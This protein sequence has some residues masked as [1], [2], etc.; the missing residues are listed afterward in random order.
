MAIVSSPVARHLQHIADS[1]VGD[2][3]DAAGCFIVCFSA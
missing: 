2:Y 3:F 1:L